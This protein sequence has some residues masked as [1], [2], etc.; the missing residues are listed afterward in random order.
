MNC[1]CCCWCFHSKITLHSSHANSHYKKANN[2]LQ[3]P[4]CKRRWCSIVS[5]KKGCWM[6]DDDWNADTCVYRLL[7]YRNKEVEFSRSV[8]VYRV[9]SKDNM[10]C[11]SVVTTNNNKIMIIN[12]SSLL[13]CV[14]GFGALLPQ[15]FLTICPD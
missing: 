12:Y 8:L 6:A 9:T 15:Y 5:P 3:H 10:C 4:C 14:S 7:S 1:C 13:R 2:T 11:N